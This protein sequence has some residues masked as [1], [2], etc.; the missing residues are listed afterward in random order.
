MT[1]K[2]YLTL[3]SFE[4]ISTFW[5]KLLSLKNHNFQ[6]IIVKDLSRKLKLNL[7]FI[8]DHSF[9]TCAKYSAKL[10]FLGVRNISFSEVFALVP[11]WWSLNIFH[12]SISLGNKKWI[13]CL[14]NHKRDWII[15]HEKFETNWYIHDWMS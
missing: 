3:C 11:N 2:N 6:K 10:R 8:R 9:S 15:C 12:R 1:W 13:S 7:F 5:Y 14:E 4:L